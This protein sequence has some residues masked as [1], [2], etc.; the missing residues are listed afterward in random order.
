MATKAERKEYINIY[1]DLLIILHHNVT[2]GE[3]F[4]SKLYSALDKGFPINF[5]LFKRKP[6]LYE[7]IEY[8]Y[9][10]DGT[11]ILL[12]A[13]AD[14]NITVGYLHRT[15]LQ[16]AILNT[17]I[18]V[19]IIKEIIDKTTDIN[20]KDIGGDSAFSLMCKI[21]FS[22]SLWTQKGFMEKAY[23]VLNMLIE[24]DADT[25]VLKSWTEADIGLGINSREDKKIASEIF[26]KI[27]ILVEQKKQLEQTADGSYEYEL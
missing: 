18:P 4:K 25:S 14:V 10:G 11:R 6:L 21:M 1:Q 2:I 12:K 19:D 20:H 5:T 24:A 3:T 26:K 9:S 22:P 15:A 13:G 23:K 16:Y 8:D 7:A 17:L 27:N